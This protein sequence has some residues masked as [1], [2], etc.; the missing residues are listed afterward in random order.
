MGS[1]G[2]GVSAYKL[3]EGYRAECM[4]LRFTREGAINVSLAV[5]VQHKILSQRNV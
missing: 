2:N 3:D 4:K 1:V 5:A